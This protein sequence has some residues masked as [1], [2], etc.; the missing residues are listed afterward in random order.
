MAAKKEKVKRPDAKH[1]IAQIIRLTCIDL[2][3]LKDLLIGAAIKEANTSAIPIVV[4]LSINTVPRSSKLNC[5]PKYAKNLTYQSR[6]MMN[7]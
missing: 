7:D 4:K 2:F 5:N 6:A 1:D 3:L